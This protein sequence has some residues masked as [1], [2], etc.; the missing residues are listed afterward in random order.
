M[1]EMLNYKNMN[2]SIELFCRDDTKLIFDVNFNN[3]NENYLIYLIEIEWNDES[4]VYLAD[5]SKITMNNL[6]DKTFY[7]ISVTIINFNYEYDKN[8]GSE[9]FSTLESNYKPLMVSNITAA[10]FVPK[11]NSNETLLDVFIEW[12]PAEGKFSFCYCFKIL[13]FF[14]YR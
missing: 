2:I 11:E 10:K 3:L 8:D 12:V 1:F 7:N 4:M 6:K 9:G 5:N 14:F 13:N